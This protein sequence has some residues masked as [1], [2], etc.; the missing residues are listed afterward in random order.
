MKNYLYIKEIGLVLIPDRNTKHEILDYYNKLTK[1]KFIEL[2]HENI[3]E[4]D[5]FYI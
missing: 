2:L 3:I 1:N 4:I 5:N